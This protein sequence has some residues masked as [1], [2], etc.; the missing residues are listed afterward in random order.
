MNNPPAFFKSSSSRANASPYL[1]V[2]S[3]S[4]ANA[5]PYL[6]KQTKLKASRKKHQCH[7][8]RN[9][10]VD[11]SVSRG[12]LNAPRGYRTKSNNFLMVCAGSNTGIVGIVP[13][14]GRRFT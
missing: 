9:A 1:V 6:K 12:S 7:K 8:K 2:V 13:Y 3:S 5:S 11:R 14:V 10:C 4:R